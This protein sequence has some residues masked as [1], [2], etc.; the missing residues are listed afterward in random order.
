MSLAQSMED[1]IKS[2]YSNQIV[3]VYSDGS[4]RTSVALFSDEVINQSD[5][6]MVEDL[7]DEYCEIAEM[8]LNAMKSSIGE[9]VFDCNATHWDELE[10][11]DNPDGM[12]LTVSVNFDMAPEESAKEV[13]EYFEKLVDNCLTDVGKKANVTSDI[14]ESTMINEGTFSEID[15]AIQ[16]YIMHV[17]KF[18]AP[19]SIDDCIDFCA[20]VLD[21]DVDALWELENGNGTISDGLSEYFNEGFRQTHRHLIKEAKKVL[22]KNGYIVK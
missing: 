21:M 7:V 8:N 20:D 17:K 18:D 11:D 3:G 4:E 19:V 12:A 9:R 16:E 2:K 6:D 22:E 14:K 5:I 10:S 13:A 1:R 15:N